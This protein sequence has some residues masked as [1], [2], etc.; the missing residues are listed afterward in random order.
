M[1]YRGVGVSSIDLLAGDVFFQSTLAAGFP[2]L[3][4][5]T[6]DQQGN[7]YFPGY[8]LVEM[9]GVTV[10]LIGMSGRAPGENAFI[11]IVDWRQALTETL[12]EV[13]G[14]ATMIVVL[15]SLDPTENEELSRT[16]PEV[17]LLISADRQLG[18]QLPR[19]HQ[20]TLISQVMNRGQFLGRMDII[21][22]P[23]GSWPAA[24]GDLH[25][26]ATLEK[27]LTLIDRQ[28]LRAEQ[29]RGKSLAA[30]QEL[31]KLYS[32]QRT[33]TSQLEELHSNLADEP[34]PALHELQS[35]LL[36]IA[37]QSGKNQRI[38]ALVGKAL[39]GQ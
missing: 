8:R 4:A 6:R 12:S 2:W 39:A 38:D 33:L 15:S 25:S 21:Y 28:I 23:G 36:P 22:R 1:G 11:D 35:T 19:L 5:N 14:R 17:D 37:P 13:A 30:A 10:A 27:R 9:S 18:N 16:F 24:G 26:T 32:Y 7:P 20:N 3:S 29:N 31:D 34:N